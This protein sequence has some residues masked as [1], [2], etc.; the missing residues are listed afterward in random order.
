MTAIT[1]SNVVSRDRSWQ[2]ASILPVDGGFILSALMAVVL[3]VAFA[4][5]A[6][7]QLYAGSV[8][9]VVKDSSGAMIAG[10]TVTLVDEERGFSFTA[11]TD[12]SGRYLFRS[13]PP[14]TYRLSVKMTGFKNESRGGIRVDVGQNVSADFVL[15]VGAGKETVNVSAE[16]PLLATQDATTGQVVDRKFI[17]DL[18]LNGRDV[19][20]LAFLAPG[21]TEVDASCIGCSANNFISNG[22]RNATADIL[23]DG[24]TTTNYEQNSGI[25]V[26]TYTPSVDAVEEFNV[27]ETNFSSEYG[28]SGA[29]IVNMVT[30]SGTNDFHGGLYEFQRYYKTD[31]NSWFNNQQGIPIPAL[32]RSNFG[33]TV[34][35]PIFKNKTFFFFDYEG[36]REDSQAGPVFYG[37][38]SDAER[39]GN[40]GELCGGDGP[41]G[42]VPGA[43][44]DANGICSDPAGQLWDPYSGYINQTAGLVMRNVPI[45][46]NDLGSYTSTVDANHP[47]NFVLA[48]NPSGAPYRLPTGPGNLIDPVAQKLMNYYPEPNVNVNNGNYN[49]Y[50]NRVDS[51]SVRSRS[52]QWDLK[53]DYRFNQKNLMSGKYSRNYSDSGSF[54]CFGNAADPCSSGPTT[55]GA[56]MFALN[57]THTFSPKTLLTVSYGLS[58]GTYFYAGVP[59]T[60]K[61]ISPVD[62]LGEPQYMKDSGYNWFPAVSVGGNYAS[63][64]YYAI[65]T[66]PWTY[67]KLGQETHHLIGTVSWIKGTHELK[68]GAEGRLHRLNYTQPNYAPGGTNYFDQTGTSNY[69]Y[70]GCGSNCLPVG[71]D[72][73]ATFLI[74]AQPNS[75]GQYE[76][77]N[78]VA[79][80]NFEAGGFVQDNWKTSDKLT[81]NLGLRYEV[82][83]PRTERHNELNW[84]DPKAI[85]PITLNGQNLL[86]GERF[87]NSNDRYSYAPSYNN[88]QPRFGFAYKLFPKMVIRG[89]YGIYFSAWRGAVAGTSGVGQQGFDEVT[90]LVASFQG[91]GATPAARMSNPYPY[92]PLKPPGSSLGLMNDVGYFGYGPIRYIS[93]KVPNEQSWSLGVQ[94]Q[95]PGNMVLDVSYIGKKGT[96]LYFANAGSLNH[97]GSWV[98]SLPVQT[99]DPCTAT[100]TVKCLIYNYVTN[101]FTDPTL[102]NASQL[103]TDPTNPLLANLTVPEDQLMV[104]YPQ[105]TYGFSGDE[106]PIANAFY[107]AL[108]IR[109]EKRFSHGLEFLATYTLSKSMDD[110]SL[111]STNNIWLGSF[112]SL[113]N[114]NNPS[115]E[116]SLSSFDIPQVLQFSYTYELPIGRGKWIGGGMNSVLNA[117]VG[118]WRTNGIWRFNSG[119]PIN[120]ALYS[121]NTLPT[122]GPMRPNII[123]LPHRAGGK[124]SDWINQYF[125]SADGSAFFAQP[126]DYTLGNAPRAWGAVRN[127]GAENADLSVFKE[128]AM[129]GIREGMRL[130]F[131]FEAFNASN[132]PQFC[133]PD[134]GFGDQNFGKIFYT[135]NAP[136]QLQLALKLYW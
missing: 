26:D 115:G 5:P 129:G 62:A 13:V 49:P 117:F 43:S 41:N 32:R 69:Q 28:F 74:G 110:A 114:P 15:Q 47:G 71:G 39:A 100:L 70:P 125:T 78:S 50:V 6:H 27:Q 31:A 46:F 64:S 3:L 134:T 83:M 76:I 116:W 123:G 127:P 97:L 8:T 104:P 12:A 107:S 93:N 95:M 60:Y 113:Q 122:Y 118:G 30:R 51:G 17:N 11:T 58:R 52:D 37:V 84:L 79:S 108:Q 75:Y 80:Q 55:G 33:G 68:F 23:M 45:P 135:C 87:A 4:T 128:F 120:P 59:S 94:Q 42:P 91:D 112:A 81:L 85:S 14:A 92:G 10:A 77:P 44:F 103:I 16:A 133:G 54:N 105:F 132:H 131:R 109:A 24:V 29:T 88:Y 22:T 9:G 35:G 56:H 124:D 61:N 130:E 119:R 90:N 57:D 65:G 121:Y 25:R 73:M 21:V 101:P 18:P 136:R 48:K 72:A 34:G 98:E 2:R 102:S 96:H 7:A 111:T 20:G 66:N 36:V 1:T 99:S 126:N 53:I 82:V 106:P 86:G 40:F 89:G 67:G 38:P 19:W 63:A